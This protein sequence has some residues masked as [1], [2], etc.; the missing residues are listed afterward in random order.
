[1]NEFLQSL[2]GGVRFMDEITA[3]TLRAYKD[4]IEKKGFA[5][6]TIHNRLLTILFLL[7]KNAIK[8][9]LAWESAPDV[10][11]TRP[12]PWPFPFGG[13]HPVTN[14]SKVPLCDSCRLAGRLP[15]LGGIC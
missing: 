1:L 2:Q 12:Y 11:F 4:S 10:S 15:P 3:H 14:E 5:G 8:N 9:P 6:N 7:K 13:F